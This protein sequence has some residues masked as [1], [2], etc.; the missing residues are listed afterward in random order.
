MSLCQKE[1]SNVIGPLTRPCRKDLPPP[2]TR[3]HG[4]CNLLHRATKEG[5]LTVVSELLRSGYRSIDAK[6]ESGQTAIHLAAILNRI[7]IL[8][9]L[10]QGGG[11]VNIKDDADLTPLH[12]RRN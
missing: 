5:N 10:I 2:D 4:R 1:G 7:E 9:L 6:N 12:V 11:N 8:R 3:C